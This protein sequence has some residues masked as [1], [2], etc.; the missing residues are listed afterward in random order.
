MNVIKHHPSIEVLTKF[1]AGEFPNSISVAI[2]IHVEMC[3][4]CKAKLETINL[5]NADSAFLAEK[6]ESDCEATNF[7]SQEMED[8]IGEITMDLSIDKV[9]PMPI[10]H[11]SVKGKKYALPTALNHLEQSNWQNLG[12]ISRSRIELDDGDLRSSMLH[13]DAGG[14]VPP[15]THS[16]FELTVLLDGSFTDDMG[17]YNK[18]DFVWLDGQHTHNPKTLDGCICYTVVSNPLHFTQG[19]SRLLN[20]IGKLIY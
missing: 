12:K 13:I 9:I 14:E 16:G 3:D 17:T 4:Q 6:T 8:L 11:F 18:G 7:L 1:A 10:K 2:S 20:P 5:H 19:V 15:H